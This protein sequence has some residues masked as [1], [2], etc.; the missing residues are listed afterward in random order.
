[1]GTQ[2]NT[3]E[4]HLEEFSKSEAGRLLAEVFFREILFI[5]GDENLSDKLV[6]NNHGMNSRVQSQ[7]VLDFQTE[8]LPGTS[9]E[10]FIL[11][12]ARNGIYHQLPEFLFHPI[13]LSTPSMTNNEVV[14][15]MRANRKKE[16]AAIKFFQ[17]FDTEF[18]LDG[19]NVF[20]RSL[21]LF[22]APYDS[23][24]LRGVSSL[25]C[26]QE[27]VLN[28]GERY[29]LFLFLCDAEI[30]KENLAKLEG[31]L[32]TIL[33]VHVS[34]QYK[35]HYIEEPPYKT[36][37]NCRL[38]VDAGLFGS[39]IGELDDV[40]AKLCFEKGIESDTLLKERT[41]SLRFVLSF[42][43]VSARCVNVLYTIKSNNGFVLGT[44]FLGYD[45]D[46]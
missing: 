22:T 2:I 37:G 15:A 24:I 43:I 19:V 13:S 20:K 30:Y 6:V 35:P 5:S 27:G 16:T 36:L 17:P 40:E 4:R 10:W 8:D 45:T 34:L 14:E 1:M 39:F 32:H 31:L 42:F 26:R 3:N 33:R 23:R 41:E 9:K 7:D 29:K 18:F 25:F 44:N 12:L 46:L 38:G 21:N 11:H 28:H